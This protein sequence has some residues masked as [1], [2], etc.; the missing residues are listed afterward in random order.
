MVHALHG[1][2]AGVL[3]SAE[4]GI[5]TA[6]GCNQHCVYCNCSMLSGRRIV[7]SCQWARPARNEFVVQR[8]GVVRDQWALPG[9]LQGKLHQD[10]HTRRRSS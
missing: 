8:D 2:G 5:V 9:M 1:A 10:L 6:R 4:A 7:P 3:Q